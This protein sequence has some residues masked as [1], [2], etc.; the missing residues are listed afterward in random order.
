MKHFVR[1]MTHNLDAPLKTNLNICEYLLT[2]SYSLFSFLNTLLSILFDFYM[3]MGS[4]R[5]RLAWFT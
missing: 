5:T 2:F 1:I 3:L 4:D